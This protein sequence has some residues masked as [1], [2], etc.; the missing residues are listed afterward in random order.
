MRTFFTSDLHFFHVN[1]LAYTDRHKIWKDVEEMNEALIQNWNE[2]VA[3]EDRVYILGDVAMGGRSKGPRLAA[4]LRRLNGTKYLIPGNHD[5][6]ILR[7]EECREEITILPP[8]YE[9]SIADDTLPKRRG[10]KSGRQRIILSHYS[11]RVWHKNGRGSWHLFGHSHGSLTGLGKSFD[12]GI[13]GPYSNFRPM[14]YEQVKEVMDGFEFVALD[15]H[16]QDT[17]YY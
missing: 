15:H 8:I 1:I 13:D 10:G 17:S 3:P 4:I 12:V 2:V 11:M 6:Y 7:D 9:L 14:S 5:S 16:D